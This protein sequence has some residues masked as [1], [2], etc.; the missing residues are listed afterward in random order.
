MSVKINY[1]YLKEVFVNSVESEGAYLKK[2]YL[3][4][5]FSAF[6]VALV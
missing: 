5:T 4:R 6:H 2:D 3:F 1:M